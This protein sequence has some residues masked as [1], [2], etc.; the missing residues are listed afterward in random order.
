MS[1][2]P[3][4]SLFGAEADPGR[5]I[6]KTTSWQ[7]SNQW[8]SVSQTIHEPSSRPYQ[9]PLSRPSPSPDTWQVSDL[10]TTSSHVAVL[11]PIWPGSASLSISII[12]LIVGKS[13]SVMGTLVDSSGQ[14][15]L[16]TMSPRSLSLG[17]I[18]GAWIC[19]TGTKGCSLFQGLISQHSYASGNPIRDYLLTVSLRR[20]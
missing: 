19:I 15:S 17:Y 4:A 5:R 6:K 20:V 18:R 2:T 9:P 13:L 8:H 12:G 7:V 1:P 14:V 16:R 3:F 10:Y 11:L